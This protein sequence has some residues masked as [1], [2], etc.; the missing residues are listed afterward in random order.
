MDVVRSSVSI[1][2]VLRHKS[3]LCFPRKGGGEVEQH[4]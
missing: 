1:A 3:F 2:K 4:V